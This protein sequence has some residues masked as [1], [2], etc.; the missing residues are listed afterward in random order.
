[1]FSE[2]YFNTAQHL[3][4]QYDLQMPLPLYLKNF[5]RANKKFGSRDR[6]Y[7]SELV[8]AFYRLPRELKISTRERMLWGA[9]LANRLPLTFLQKYLPDINLP[10]EFS[11]TD[12]YKVFEVRYG[13]HQWLNLPLSGN[14][15][16]DRYLNYFL[17]PKSFFLRIRKKKEEIISRLKKNQIAFELI[18]HHCIRLNHHTELKDILPDPSSYTIQDL[19]T[20]RCADYFSPKDHDIWWD[21][22]AAS[23]GKSL[24][25]LDKNPKVDLYMSD[26]RESIIENLKGRLSVYGYSA[27][28]KTYTMDASVIQQLPFPSPQVIICDV[29]CSGSGTWAASPEQLYFFTKEK[30]LSFHHKQFQIASNVARFLP[31]GGK[32]FYIT[33][34][35]FRQENEEVVVRLITEIGLELKSMHFIDASEHGGDFI[36]FAEL[37]KT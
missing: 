8:F 4:D 9:L 27:L 25:V 1:M 34:S 32:L 18:G 7:I 36:F 10:D 30:C 2:A 13:Q 14:Y 3:I 12:I 19:A 24:L 37:D 31:S 33:C 23:G 28:K 35:I 15:H 11:F 21:C 6:R 5:Y 16:H 29:P 20:Q 22:C 26:V 17:K